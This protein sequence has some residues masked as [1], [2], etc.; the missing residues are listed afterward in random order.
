MTTTSYASGTSSEPLLG[1]TIGDNFDRAVQQHADRTALVSVH[2][3][4]RLTYAQLG[5]LVDRCARGLLALGIAREDRVGIWAPNRHEWT[6][7]QY[8]TAKV[9]AILVNINPAYRTHEVAYV[10]EQA[11]VRLLVA[12]STFKTSD[13]RKMIDEVRPGLTA[14]EDTVFLDTPDWDDLLAAA[15]GATA[16]ALAARQQQLQFDDPINIQYTSGTTGF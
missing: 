14:L 11:G 5:A 13:Y 15:R 1:E 9:G 16:E 6:V 2:E 3:G 8:A 10:L 12:A 7:V 4:V